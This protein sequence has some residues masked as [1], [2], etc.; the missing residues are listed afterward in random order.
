MNTHFLCFEEKKM[1]EARKKTNKRLRIVFLMVYF[2]SPPC[3]FSISQRTTDVCVCV[4]VCIYGTLTLAVGC[5]LSSYIK[6]YTNILTAE[7]ILGSCNEF[8]E[9]RIVFSLNFMFYYADKMS[10]CCLQSLL[11]FWLSFKIV[12]GTFISIVCNIIKCGERGE[13]TNRKQTLNKKKSARD[14]C[15][16]TEIAYCNL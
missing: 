14:V 13:R 15:S 8:S 7:S 3:Q 2:F 9:A 11:L 10:L 16:H 5:L 4:C 6:R 12:N 1:K